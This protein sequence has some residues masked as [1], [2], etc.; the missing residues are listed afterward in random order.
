MVQADSTFCKLLYLVLNLNLIFIKSSTL[1][2]NFLARLLELLLP[3]SKLLCNICMLARKTEL[4]G[5]KGVN[6]L[7]PSLDFAL[8]YLLRLYF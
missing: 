3:L 8:F 2:I 4:S 1:F 6:L 7:F 5:V